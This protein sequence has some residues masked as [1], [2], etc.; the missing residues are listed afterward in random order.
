[1]SDSG[2]TLLLPF[3]QDSSATTL[4]L[5][6]EN[7]L[8]EIGRIQPRDN[9]QVISNRYDVYQH[10]CSRGLEVQF[11]DY[12][13]GCFA[14]ASFDR[15]VYRV[16]KEKPVVHHVINQASRLLAAGGQ[17]TIAGA[18]G[19]GIKT[20]ADKAATLLGDNANARKHGD[21][22]LARISKR[23]D[24]DSARYLDDRD[25]TTLRKITELQ[26]QAVFSKPGVFGWDKV[27]A[28]SQLLI[29]AAYNAGHNTPPQ[30]L[31]DLG[32][33]YGYLTLCSADWPSLKHRVATDNNAAA[34]LCMRHNAASFGMELDVLAD[35]AGSAIDQQF[36]L[37][38]CNPPFHQGFSVDSVLTRKF[39]QAAHRLLARQGTALFVV[40]QFI[41]IERP[42]SA[43]FSDVVCLNNN[44]KFKVL[45]L[46]KS[47]G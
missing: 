20:Y 39:L 47:G 11:N 21:C 45:S 14:D 22:Y 7:L 46:R 24:H 40:N 30:S 15:I 42:A 26:G 41:G 32:C 6:D 23:A 19:D 33:G 44:G 16:S 28:G 34:L 4:W 35:D 38:L 31:L 3:L 12:A 25:Y 5:A 36:D 18:K 27:D 8:G 37:I 2:F 17:L 10:G 29:E 9:L 43:L 13:L 1:M